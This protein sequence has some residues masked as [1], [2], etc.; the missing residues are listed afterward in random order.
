[1]AESRKPAANTIDGLCKAMEVIA[2]T[3]AA[4][5]WDNVGL[6]AG[7]AGWPLRR[8]MLTI[9]LTATVMAEAVRARADA[10]IAYHPPIFRPISRLLADAGRQ[11]AVILEALSHKIAVYSPHT[12][13]DAAA[14][15]TNEALADLAGLSGL[16][17]FS[18]VSPLRHECK[19]V[20]FIPHEA[21]DAV[22][23]AL[24][25]AGA[26]RIGNYDKCSYRLRGE[27]TFFGSGAANPR[28]GRRGRLERVEETRLE[29][30]VPRRR[31]ADVTAALRSS[32]PYEEPA[33]DIYP[34]DAPPTSDTGQGRI[35]RFASPRPLA[36]LARDL[37]AKTRAA[38]PV[39]V[40][41]A[42]TR[43]RRGYVCAGS[44]GRLPLEL[45]AEPCG[46]GDVV[47][48]GEISHHAAL[49]YRRRGVC[50]IALGHWASERPV[51]APL[52]SRLREH[53]P[54]ASFVVSRADAEPLRR[55]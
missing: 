55:A 4:A 2:P 5:E 23:D 46:P 31:L 51:L 54:R 22:A 39:I 9:D 8:A 17:P 25:A 53:L 21:L 24:F 38:A 16:R 6:L 47:I 19:L 52:A 7:D 27:G 10:I 45:P 1:M 44:A 48:T 29:V 41:E 33:F 43:L 34:L 20:T 37:A 28:V 35:G 12:A 3:W 30:V 15:G 49:E 14:G 13:L 42:A 36:R 11:E 40:G 32:H 26:G 50:V 18:S